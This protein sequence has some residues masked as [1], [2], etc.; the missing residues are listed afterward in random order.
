MEKLKISDIEKYTNGKLIK[1]SEYDEI[2]N[3]SID[4]RLV[5]ENSLFVPIIGEKYDAHN[6]MKEVYEKGCKNFLCDKNHEFVFDANVVFVDNT[7]IALGNIAKGYRNRFSIPFI[8]ITGSVGKTSTKDIVSSV[9][10][11]KYNVL[12]NEGNLNNNIGVP[13]TLFNLTNET[14]IGVIEMGMDKKGELDY[15]SNIV[16]PDI[17]VITNIGQSHIMNFENG[18]DGIFE[19]KMEIVNGLKKDGILIVN[20]DDEYLS[21]LKEKDHFYK[22]LTYG[23]NSDNDI[24]VKNYKIENNLIDF[25]FVYENKEYS[26]TLSSIAKHNIGNAL[27]AIL[28][29][30]HYDLSLNDIQDGLMNISFSKNRLDIFDTDKYKIINDT[31]NA[32]Y[33]SI[34][35]ALEVLNAF[36]GRKVAILGDILEL[37]SYS[38][39]IHRKIGKNLKSDL[40]I[41]I[42]N[43]AKYINEETNV[44]NYYF[45]TKQDF[46]SKAKDLLK[47]ND[48]ILLKGSRGIELD[49][50]VDFLKNN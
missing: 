25:D 40:L 17:A 47:Q 27:I 45:P 33:D 22:L 8:G 12:K 39:E 11:T 7:E 49:K 16:N 50:V 30:L 31:Y 35:S 5:D 38:E 18:R 19:A 2:S 29:G 15:L 14:E 13:R 9:L 10:S 34:M 24:Y 46:Y 3:I 48:I 42:G 44:E 4:S 26:F 32:S 41:T 20:G 43:D 28:I 21:K 37:G 23:F 6:F 36:E 1:K